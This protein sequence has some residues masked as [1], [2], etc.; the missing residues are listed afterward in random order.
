MIV[1]FHSF[2]VL[3]AFDLPFEIGTFAFSL[4]FGFKVI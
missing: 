2:D 3:E 1:V 4:E